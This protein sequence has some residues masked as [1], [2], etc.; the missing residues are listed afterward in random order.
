MTL[1]VVAGVASAVVLLATSTHSGSTGV[2]VRVA[3]SATYGKVLVVGSGAL[4]GFP[5][6]EFSGD[7]AGHDG[8]GLTRAL[9]SDVGIAARLTMTCTGPMKDLIDSVT[10]DDWPALTTSARPVAGRGV[11]QALLGVVRRPGIG[12]QVTY[13]GHLL[14]LFDP[15]S[16][17]FAPQGVDYVETVHP[18]APW[19]GTWFL[20]SARNGAPVAGPARMAV[21]L[22]ANGRPT[23]TVETDAN[24]YPLHFDVYEDSADSPGHV[25][26]RGACNATW[27]PVVTTGPPVAGAG[28]AS[29]VLGTV[30]LA[31]GARQVTYNGHPLYLYAREQISVVD[32]KTLARGA[33]QGN[34]D[35]RRWGAGQFTLVSPSS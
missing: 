27:I 13:G 2:R 33:T 10:S 1:F 21:G 22:L 20:V 35:H 9:G 14:Y 19:H 12:D 5:L 7:V 11:D 31:D 3:S 23:V 4:T 17:P 29:G 16:A 28:V 34:G 32:H 18:F 8:C 15:P 25:A 6:Y 24:V 30:A 26:C